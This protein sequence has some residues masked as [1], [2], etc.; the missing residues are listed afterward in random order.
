MTLIKKIF[1]KPHDSACFSSVTLAFLGILYKNVDNDQSTKT[2]KVYVCENGF[3]Y[4]GDVTEGK[5]KTGHM[6]GVDDR[7]VDIPNIL[8]PFLKSNKCYFG[9]GILFTDITL[10]PFSFGAFLALGISFF[11]SAPLDIVYNFKDDV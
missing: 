11:V 1:T 4:V 7:K 8:V 9:S 2:S 10:F 6:I 5:N 3:E